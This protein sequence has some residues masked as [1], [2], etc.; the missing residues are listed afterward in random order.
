MPATPVIPVS[1]LNVF[2]DGTFDPASGHGGWSFVACRG[3]LEITF[4]HGGVPQTSNNA[5]ELMALLKAARWLHQSAGAEPAV[6]WT[7]SLYVVE[8][9]N[10]L[11]PIWRN[12]GWT[13]ISANAHRRRRSIPDRD[14]WQA[15]DVELGRN[16][17]ITVAW[18][19]GHSGL[20]GNERADALAETARLSM[21][22]IRSIRTG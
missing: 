5:M 18:C 9:C 17:L 21:A 7:D 11:R 2:T 22:K 8:G 3:D 13:V 10:R 19:K 12:N 14:L 6:L 15:V 1:A 4:D 16:P 20:V